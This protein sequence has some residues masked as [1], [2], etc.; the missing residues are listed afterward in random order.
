MVYLIM[1]SVGKLALSDEDVRNYEDV[2]E[3]S[4]SNETD[5]DNGGIFDRY[6]DVS[7]GERYKRKRNVTGNSSFLLNVYRTFRKYV[8]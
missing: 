1:L 2:G 8:T 5:R 3:R 7:D 4:L 6:L